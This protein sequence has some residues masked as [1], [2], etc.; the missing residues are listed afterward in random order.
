[1]LTETE[2]TKLREIKDKIKDE[3]LAS[4][5]EKAIEGWSRDDVVPNSPLHGK[6][7]NY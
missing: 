1:M 2:L 4:I 6:S 5:V 7:E 3:C